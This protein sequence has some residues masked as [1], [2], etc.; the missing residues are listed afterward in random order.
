VQPAQSGEYRVTV[1]N[2]GGSTNSEPVSL[3]VLPGLDIHLVPAIALLG[4]VGQNY[5]L[6]YIDEFGPVTNWLPLATVTITNTGQLYLDFSAAG[7]RARCYRLVQ[8]P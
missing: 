1:T 5:R 8:V 4:E 7:H 6:D 3:S 2:G